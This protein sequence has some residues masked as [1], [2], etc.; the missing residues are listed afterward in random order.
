MTSFF[1]NFFPPE[2]VTFV[3]KRPKDFSLKVDRNGL[4]PD[5]KEYLSHHLGF[6]LTGAASVCQVHGNKIID[7]TGLVDD[8]DKEILAEADGI[9]TDKVD[10]PVLVRTADC[11]PI[12]LYSLG[13][14]RI[15]LLHAGWKGTHQ[16]ILIEGL[17]LMD[18]DPREVKVAFGPSIR[19][20]CYKVG[21]DVKTCFP[22]SV[23]E[24]DG[25]YYLDLVDVSKKQAMRYGVKAE[26]ISDC[27]I[28]TCCNEEYFSYRR[29]GENAGRMISLM[30]LTISKP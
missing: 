17:R 20:C 12:F 27:N 24:R 11:I 8:R 14:K 16:E 5:Q 25:N 15:G 3:S 23:D 10:L 6:D 9:V 19:R 7:I 18:S 22:D 21:D 1:N 4:T 2:V 13:R 29:D 28:C 30:M 26:N